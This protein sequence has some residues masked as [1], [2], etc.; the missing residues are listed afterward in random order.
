M[1]QTDEDGS[2]FGRAEKSQ[3]LVLE[4]QLE[5]RRITYTPIPIERFQTPILPGP[6][7]SHRGVAVVDLVD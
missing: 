1:N 5:N 6:V 2:N 4:T 7:A 3:A